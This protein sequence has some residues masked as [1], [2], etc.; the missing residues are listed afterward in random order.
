M[1]KLIIDDLRIL[2]IPGEVVYA[3]TVGAALAY[4]Q[5]DSSWEEIYLDHDLGFKTGRYEDIWDVIEYFETRMVENPI[6]VGQIFIITAN[7]VGRQKMKLVFDKMGYPTTVLDPNP[8]LGGI[9][10]W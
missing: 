4:L 8:L 1:T 10:P 7:P 3:R 5:T 9:L 2:N 6:K